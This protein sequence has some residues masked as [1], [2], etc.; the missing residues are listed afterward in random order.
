MRLLSH[1]IAYLIIIFRCRAFQSGKFFSS[2]RSMYM[3]D[4]TTKKVIEQSRKF[5]SPALEKRME[6]GKI[7]ISELNRVFE[8]TKQELS[9]IATTSASGFVGI[10]FSLEGVLVD[11]SEIYIDAFSTLA[12]ELG[13]PVPRVEKVLDIIGCNAKESFRSLQWNVPCTKLSEVRNSFLEIF[14]EVLNKKS[15]KAQPGA[16]DALLA[17]IRNQDE[18]CIMTALPRELAIRSLVM[19]GLSSVLQGRVDPSRLIYP[20]SAEVSSSGNDI[21]EQQ[22]SRSSTLMRCCCVLRKPSCLVAVVDANPRT[23]IEA[24][25]MGLA[26]FMLRGA[27]LCSVVYVLSDTNSNET[28]FVSN[29]LGCFCA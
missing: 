9:Y 20:L 5:I 10:I 22:A 25:R 8:P 23:V 17:A 4:E 6:L 13:Y 11:F 26:V 18:I 28:S 12:K 14:A 21:N 15:V 7:S 3:V 29:C 16:V 27:H 24:K 19:T 2:V 1:G